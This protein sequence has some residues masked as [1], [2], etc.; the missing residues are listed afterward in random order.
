MTAHTE[1]NWNAGDTYEEFMGRWSRP[2][3][4]TFIDWLDAP[5]D[6][7]WLD[8]DATWEIALRDFGF[9]VTDEWDGDSSMLL[10]VNPDEHH[11]VEGDPGKAKE[12]MLSHLTPRQRT[13]RKQ[14]LEGLSKWVSD[15]EGEMNRD[16]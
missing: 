7:H 8:V 14:F 12:E 2:L 11:A 9:P 4:E 13:L 15:L 6:G 5:H 3:A 1:D 16:V 10:T